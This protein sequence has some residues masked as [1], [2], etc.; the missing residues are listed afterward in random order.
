MYTIKKFAELTNTTPRTI[1]YY[2]EIGLLTPSRN[3]SGYRIYSEEDYEKVEAIQILKIY[4]LSLKEI[5]VLIQDNSID[6]KQ[7]IYDLQ[8][9]YLSQQIQKLE[10]QKEFL[11]QRSQ[12]LYLY[13]EDSSFCKNICITDRFSF[14]PHKQWETTDF[15]KTGLH[16]IL[17][18]Y[19]DGIY[20]GYLVKDI[21][22]EVSFEKNVL[23]GYFIEG[24]ISEISFPQNYLLIP[25]HGD[26]QFFVAFCLE[27]IKY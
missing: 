26:D 24:N 19:Q 5:Q 27:I 17:E 12:L 18:W 8:I 7:H 6:K 14:F 2:E 23:K 4:G 3:H 20:Q 13:K 21:Q 25:F 16:T 9:Q 11:K 15:L 1:K 10:N 22:G